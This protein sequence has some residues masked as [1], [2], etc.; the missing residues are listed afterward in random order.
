MSADRP[1]GERLHVGSGTL[2][3]TLDGSKAE[4][5]AAASRKPIEEGRLSAALTHLANISY[6]TGRALE[7]DA[8]SETFGA[9]REANGYLSREY[10]R[11]FEVPA[12]V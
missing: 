2:W 7:V 9:N 4:A 1:Q 3:G 11:P 10:R 6:R 5:D 8:D 12:R